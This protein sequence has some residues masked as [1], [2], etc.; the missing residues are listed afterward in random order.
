MLFGNKQ[1]VK[2]ASKWIDFWVSKETRLWLDHI[3]LPLIYLQRNP[4]AKHT[5]LMATQAL[6]KSL[7]Y[8]INAITQTQCA[9]CCH[10][11]TRTGTNEIQ[12]VGKNKRKHSFSRW[13]HYIMFH[14]LLWGYSNPAGCY[15][16]KKLQRSSWLLQKYTFVGMHRVTTP[17][18]S[19]SLKKKVKNRRSHQFTKAKL[20]NK[21][22]LL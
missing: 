3:V 5:A 20:R 21:W 19:S 6:S 2:P 4:E 1:E 11:T 16:F 15:T 9:L 13:T 17:G 22:H 8:I 12:S 7:Q 18:A 10:I 14:R